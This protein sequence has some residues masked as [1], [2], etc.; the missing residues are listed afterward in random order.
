MSVSCQLYHKIGTGPKH[1]ISGWKE[2]CG[3]E[4]GKT[5]SPQQ[6]PPK[7]GALERCRNGMKISG[8]DILSF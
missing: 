5:R 8:S 4:E 7:R 6:S 1:G 3:C 2:G